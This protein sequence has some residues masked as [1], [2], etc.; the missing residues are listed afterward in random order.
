[1]Y[2]VNQNSPLICKFAGC[3][4]MFLAGCHGVRLASFKNCIPGMG[5]GLGGGASEELFP[6]LKTWRL[7]PAPLK[8]ESDDIRRIETITGC[9]DVTEILPMLLEV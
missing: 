3:Q 2:F 9:F 8:T 5:M 1:M 4:V 6:W 7:E